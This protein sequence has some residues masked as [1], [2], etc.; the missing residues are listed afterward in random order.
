MSSVVFTYTRAA[1]VC[2]V[3]PL[4]GAK[5]SDVSA[6]CLKPVLPV[7]RT[8]LSCERWLWGVTTFHP[9][10]ILLFAAKNCRRQALGA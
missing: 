3:K 10:L 7:R 6:P 5:C 9:V 8:G 1:A 4:R 2:R